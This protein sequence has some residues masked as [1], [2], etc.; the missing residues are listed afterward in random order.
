MISW[1]IVALMFGSLIVPLIHIFRNS[2]CLCHSSELVP[3][4][5]SYKHW[6]L[7]PHHKACHHNCC[8]K[9]KHF[10]FA[11]CIL[12]CTDNTSTHSQSPHLLLLYM[13]ASAW[14]YANQVA[15]WLST[16]A[17]SVH[18]GTKPI[19]TSVPLLRCWPHLTAG[20]YGNM[21]WLPL[22][23]MSCSLNHRVV[24]VITALRS[25]ILSFHPYCTTKAHC[26]S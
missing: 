3:I 9:W 15:T 16:K 22:C 2:P 20:C 19:H 13:L 10:P 1:V 5:S 21:S 17:A 8:H 6:W 7:S 24:A 18:I 4:L 26:I 14:K 25:A 12:L 23:L 11:K